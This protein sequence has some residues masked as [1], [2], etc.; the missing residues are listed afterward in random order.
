MPEQDLH[1]I[2]A[3]IDNRAMTTL[4]AARAYADQMIADLRSEL[5]LQRVD[6]GTGKER[7]NP[8]DLPADQ[9]ITYDQF[10]WLLGPN[11]MKRRTVEKY[12]TDPYY[13]GRF[14]AGH[15]I[16]RGKP[17]VWKAGD[18]AAWFAARGNLEV[19]Q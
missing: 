4:L 3:E 17:V 16:T 15:R 13:K 1:L 14:V 12:G 11:P 18:V 7:L 5:A 6:A 9:L 8:A 10:S 2:R 19:G